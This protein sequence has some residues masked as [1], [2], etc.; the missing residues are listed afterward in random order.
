MLTQE[1]LIEQ[2][3]TA[4]NV[5]IMKETLSDDSHVFNV[6][7]DVDG[8]EVSFGARNEAMA[9]KLAYAIRDTSWIAAE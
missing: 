1:T 2:V 5:R 8:V 4:N 7:M 3:D 6:R 9:R